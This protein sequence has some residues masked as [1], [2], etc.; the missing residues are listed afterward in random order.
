MENLSKS[1]CFVVL[2]M[3]SACGVSEPKQEAFSFVYS[4]PEPVV[5]NTQVADAST[6]ESLANLAPAA[7]G[8]STIS[9]TYTKHAPGAAELRDAQNRKAIRDNKYIPLGMIR[10]IPSDY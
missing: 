5:K 6:P 8:T 7:G 10:S 2:I 1:F 4:E 3:L 9:T